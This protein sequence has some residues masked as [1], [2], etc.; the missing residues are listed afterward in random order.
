MFCPDTQHQAS[1]CGVIVVR[2]HVWVFIVI[3]VLLVDA[4][5]VGFIF[6]AFRAT[7]QNRAHA[8]K[9]RIAKSAPATGQPKGK[10]LVDLIAA[11]QAAGKPIHTSADFKQL[12]ID[13]N[14]K[15]YTEVYKQY[16]QRS[17]KWDEQVFHMFEKCDEYCSDLAPQPDPRAF[18]ESAKPLY[19][20]ACKDAAVQDCIALALELAGDP[21]GAEPHLRAALEAFPAS[22]YCRGQ[23][24]PTAIALAE[25][26][27]RLGGLKDQ[28]V[29]K[30]VALGQKWALEA[31]EAPPL[32]PGAQR[33]M[34]RS[35]DS[36][37]NDFYGQT[38]RIDEA[39]LADKKADQWLAH[40]AAAEIEIRQGW[41]ARGGDAASKVTAEGWKGFGEHLDKAR[42]HLL[43]A[44]ELHPEFPEAAG[45]MITITMAG[46]GVRGVSERDWFNRAAEA[47]LDNDDVYWRY[48]TC[49]LPRWG[50]NTDAIYDLGVECLE[51]KRYDIALPEYLLWLIA[52]MD[53]D[54]GAS[55][56]TRPGVYDKL[57]EMCQGAIAEPKQEKRHTYMK[58]VWAVIAWR[59]GQYQD[60]RRLLEELGNKASASPSMDYFHKP[61]SAIRNE[62]YQHT[63]G[64]PKGEGGK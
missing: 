40:M 3:A 11:Q 38:P 2:R 33:I 30:W 37:L 59:C 27:H 24:W 45:R 14:R 52:Y 64:K 28:E 16:G 46:Y 49:L 56:W 19:D 21:A 15:T 26:C 43:K 31:A 22:K 34:W 9:E 25:V 8:A 55:Y 29:Q 48:V 39:L 13:W 57:K 62:V 1:I 44:Y 42:E 4:G 61:L 36:C 47:E 50:G 51:T 7:A 54:E 23:S 60:A 18:I 63:G 41:T 32:L 5:A 53:R 35:L 6:H 10:R 58:T 20:T 12:I 17:P